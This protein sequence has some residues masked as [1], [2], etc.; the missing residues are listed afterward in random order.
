LFLSNSFVPRNCYGLVVTFLTTCNNN[1]YGC[2]LGC[3]GKKCYGSVECETKPRPNGKGE[4][5]VNIYLSTNTN[6]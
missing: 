6:L 3:Q 5:I 1:G 2:P 4:P